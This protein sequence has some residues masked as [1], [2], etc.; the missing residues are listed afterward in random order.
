MIEESM[1]DPCNGK[2]LIH[3]PIKNSYTSKYNGN[4]VENRPRISDKL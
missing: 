4:P 3:K 2:V 1:H